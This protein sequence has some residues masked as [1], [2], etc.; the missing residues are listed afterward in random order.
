M[1]CLGVHHYDTS[2]LKNQLVFDLVEPR[3]EEVLVEEPTR[4]EDYHEDNDIQG[5]ARFSTEAKCEGEPGCIDDA[6]GNHE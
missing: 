5:E 2:G 1:N 6:G 3:A 4:P